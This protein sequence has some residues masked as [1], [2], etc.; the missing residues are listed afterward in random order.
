MGVFVIT[1][2]LWPLEK[3]KKS[4]RVG[5]LSPEE[6]NFRDLVLDL[7]VV[8]NRDY[9]FFDPAYLLRLIL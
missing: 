3:R 4:Q 5:W 6:L 9:D 7:V 1:G 2:H 8:A